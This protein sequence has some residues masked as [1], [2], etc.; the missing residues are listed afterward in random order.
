M[1]TRELYE[2]LVKAGEGTYP[3]WRTLL[4]THW[5]MSLEWYK[6]FR[7]A[8]LPP[9]ADDEA[10]DET[11]WEPQPGDMLI[12]WPVTVT[13]DGGSPHLVDGRPA[14]LR[15]RLRRLDPKMAG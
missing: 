1:N 7:R 2:M 10:R 5:V 14:E 8:S 11:R 13:E 4:T 3:E 12:G 6:A 9:D 15:A